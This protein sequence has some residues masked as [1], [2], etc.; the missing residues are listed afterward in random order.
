MTDVLDTLLHAGQ[1]LHR[2]GRLR[3]MTVAEIVEDTGRTFS[4]V[5]EALRRLQRRGL[6]VRSRNGQPHGW[7]ATRQ[8][9]ALAPTDGRLR[10]LKPHLVA[11]YE[12]IL[13]CL[14]KQGTATTRQ[15]ADAAR[16]STH[17]V[18]GDLQ[19]LSGQGLVQRTGRRKYMEETKR[20]YVLWTLAGDL[21]ASSLRGLGPREG[22]SGDHT[23][24]APSEEVS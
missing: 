20:S 6:A 18:N 24:W 11:R 14:K 4:S 21:A 1:R 23:G 12:A 9:V 5:H 13:A 2:P 3:Q 17:T 8:A 10:G 7:A 15:M 16:C 22:S 19:S